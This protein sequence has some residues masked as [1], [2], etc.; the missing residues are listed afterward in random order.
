MPLTVSI[1]NNHA[2]S[3]IIDSQILFT[4][5]RE[6]LREM[7]LPVQIQNS[8]DTGLFT[9]RNFELI[10]AVLNK[11]YQ[12]IKIQN[13]YGNIGQSILSNMNDIIQKMKSLKQ[14][15]EQNN[16]GGGMF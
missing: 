5:L 15:A 6:E 8:D 3:D 4:L 9:I 16:Q 10:I 2:D 12:E 13:L 1:D 11:E 14:I 7:D